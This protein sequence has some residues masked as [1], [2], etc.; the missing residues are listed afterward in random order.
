MWSRT[1]SEMARAQAL[2]LFWWATPRMIIPMQIGSFDLRA[3]FVGAVFLFFFSP[4]PS[5]LYNDLR[6][7][8]R[9]ANGR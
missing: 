4:L 2:V 7:S 5:C 9:G 8:F 3:I 1:T 6:W